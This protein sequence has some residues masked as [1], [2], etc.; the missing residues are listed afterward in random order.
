MLRRFCFPLALIV[1]LACLIG[2][3]SSDMV[4][5]EGTVTLDGE[6]LEGASIGFIPVEGGR[7]AVGHTDAQGRFTITSLKAGDGMPPGEY[8]VTVIKV[9]AKKPSQAAPAEEGAAEEGSGENALMGKID[10]SVRFV[11]PMNFSLPST[12]PL[13]F[14]VQPGM[15]P[16]KIDLVSD[17]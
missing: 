17:K 10:Q 9:E 12:T 8:S 1:G 5:T 7:P 14:D 11:T 15:K 2:C 13:K 16:I 6:P 3:N 4:P